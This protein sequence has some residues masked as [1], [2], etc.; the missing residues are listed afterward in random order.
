M[1]DGYRIR[2][3]SLGGMVLM[4]RPF[5]LSTDWEEYWRVLQDPQNLKVFAEVGKIIISKESLSP[6][7]TWEALL[8]VPMEV[9]L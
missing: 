8:V 5:A 7:G 6:C 1:V 2:V 9:T 3:Q 4:Q